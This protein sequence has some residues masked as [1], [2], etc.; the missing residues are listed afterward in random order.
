MDTVHRFLRNEAGQDLVEY[1]LLIVFVL[2]ASTIILQQTGSSVVPIWV[3]GDA[4]VQNAATQS[5]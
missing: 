1:S 5:S 3:A 4:I 2:I